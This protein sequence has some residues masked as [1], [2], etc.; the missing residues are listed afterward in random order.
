MKTASIIHFQTTK[1][2]FHI[3]MILK[4]EDFF[5]LRYFQSE[6]LKNI[7]VTSRLEKLNLM[8]GLAEKNQKVSQA[9]IDVIKSLEEF[10]FEFNKFEHGITQKIDIAM[11]SNWKH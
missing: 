2:S 8:F 11:S 10:Y 9:M 4:D 7:L 3:L 5:L 6:F 1:F